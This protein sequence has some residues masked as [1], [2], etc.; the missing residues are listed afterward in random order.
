MSRGSV[1]V[2]FSSKASTHFDF[3]SI[4]P[5]VKHLLL[6]EDTSRL[7]EMRP[8]KAADWSLSQTFQESNRKAKKTAAKASAKAFDLGDENARLWEKID[9][10]TAQLKAKSE[11]C[12]ELIERCDTIAGDVV[13]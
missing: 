3:G 2:S 4:M 12:E 5:Q 11:E 13:L 8:I 10:L 1:E 7:R 6:P 9:L